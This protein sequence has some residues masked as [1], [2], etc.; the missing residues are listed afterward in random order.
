M[1]FRHKRKEERKNRSMGIE[2]KGIVYI[3]IATMKN[4][5]VKLPNLKIAKQNILYDIECKK[6]T[7]ARSDLIESLKKKLEDNST[8]DYNNIEHLMSEANSKKTL[9]NPIDDINNFINREDE[10]KLNTSNKDMSRRAYVKDLKQVIEGSDV[11][12]EVLDARDPLSCRS[13]ELESQIL[14]HKDEKKIILILNKIDL[15]PM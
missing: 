5:N 15:V 11:I 14:S 12:L 2:S 10:L 3:Y 8:T 9:Y 4:Q 7:S 1:T 13:K 6:Q